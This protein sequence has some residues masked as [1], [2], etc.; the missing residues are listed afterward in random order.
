MDAMGEP[1][2]PHI[3]RLDRL[4]H[5]IVERLVESPPENYPQVGRRRAS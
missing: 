4:D 2:P 5:V 1:V 3:L